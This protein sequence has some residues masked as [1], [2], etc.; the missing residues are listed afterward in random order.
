MTADKQPSTVGNGNLN[1]GGRPKGSPNK[2]TAHAKEAFQLAF[3]QLGGVE[4]LVNWAKSD[5]S[6]LTDFYKLYARLIPMEVTGKDGKGLAVVS[7]LE[8]AR[9]M[10]FMLELGARQQ[11]TT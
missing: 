9:E 3:D 5:E 8:V 6:H 2:F 11:P 10:A 1:R 7:P 4:G